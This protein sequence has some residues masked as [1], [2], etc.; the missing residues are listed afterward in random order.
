MN[1]TIQKI[2]DSDITFIVLVLSI[3]GVSIIRGILSF[4]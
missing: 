1:K 2:A 4:I 3:P